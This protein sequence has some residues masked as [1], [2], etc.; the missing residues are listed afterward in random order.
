MTIRMFAVGG[1][2]CLTVALPAAGKTY[3][4]IFPVACSEVWT[5]VQETL[6]D[7]EHYNV[8]EKDNAK[9]T[10]AYHPKHTVHV[11]V[12][13]TLL[14]RTNHVTLL[15]KGAACEMHVVSNF[16][17]WEHDDQGDFKKRVEEALAKAKNAP[18]AGPAKQE[19][20]AK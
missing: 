13:G 1:F 18:E 7:A 15:P 5:A 9:M 16:S 2:V 19:A 3:K 20:P 6:G 12:S 10:A 11:N 17:G 14:Q 4:S 8:T